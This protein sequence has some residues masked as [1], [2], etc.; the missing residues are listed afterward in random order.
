MTATKILVI[1]SAAPNAPQWIRFCLDRTKKWCQS[2]GYGYVF[3]GDELFDSLP[4][5]FG[6]RPT[7]EFEKV[8]LS[9]YARLKAIEWHLL[10]NN[11]TT[12]VWMDSDI[13]IIDEVNFGFNGLKNFACQEVWHDMRFLGKNY[14]TSKTNNCIIGFDN[15]RFVQ[16]MITEME[17]V[18]SNDKISKLM[19]G[20]MFLTKQFP[21]FPVIR[22]VACPGLL[23][24]NRLLKSFVSSMDYCRE[25]R[26]KQGWPIHAANLCA[27]SVN[28]SKMME[29]ISILDDNKEILGDSVQSPIT[30]VPKTIKKTF[31]YNMAIFLR[32]KFG[33]NSTTCLQNI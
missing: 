14:F 8:T 32:S 15:L 25:I 18:L 1:Q 17:C 5:H 3:H 29:I 12:V 4:T 33:R 31:G 30:I 27:N 22:N 28:A 20:P 10:R 23:A 24:Q 13:L 9:D 16:C 21:D 6:G 26:E 7:Q 2:K 11:N 19:A